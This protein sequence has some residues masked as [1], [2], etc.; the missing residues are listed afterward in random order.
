MLACL[1]PLAADVVITGADK[2]DI[3]VMIFP[4]P[5]AL[6]AKGYSLDD[7]DGALSD[8]ALLA[9]INARLAARGATS[10][11]TRIARALVLAE[12]PSLPDGEM[13]AKGNLNFRK[14]L[15]RRAG[16][17]ARLHGEGDLCVTTL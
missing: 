15:T 14:V 3:G 17:L 16:L 8:P 6:K 10:S 7:T 2:D 12:P 4:S 9:D 1:A 5:G 13:T 11:S